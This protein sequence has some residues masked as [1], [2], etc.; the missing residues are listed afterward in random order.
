M[1]HTGDLQSGIALALQ[2]QKAVLCFIHDSS[3]KSTEW[4]Y[5]ILSD[6]LRERIQAQAIALKIQAGSQEAGFLTPIC[7]VNSNPAIIVIKDGALK[8]NLQA[9][10]VE[11][12]NLNDRLETIFDTTTHA[13]SP[14]ESDTAMASIRA[15]GPAEAATEE[16]GS[17]PPS[18]TST[19][20]SE[21]LTLPPPE[22]QFRLPNNAYDAMR[23]LTQCLLNSNTPPSEVYQSQLRILDRLPILRQEV[24]RLRSSTSL[25][26]LSDY[27]RD[28]LLRMPSAA[29]KAQAKAESTAPAPNP[30][31]STSAPTTSAPPQAQHAASTRPNPAGEYVY[32]QPSSSQLQSET[33]HDEEKAAAAAK[34]RQ[35]AALWTRMQRERQAKDRE[36]R[37]RIKSQIA[38]DREERRRLTEVRS[39]NDRIAEAEAAEAARAAKPATGVVRLQVRTFDGSTLR[40]TFQHDS[41][42]AND[43]RPWI[44]E[45]TDGNVPYNLKLI[46]TP[47]P[48]RN[49]EAS[50]EGQPLSDLGIRGSC[51]L[52]MVPVKGYVESYTGNTSHGLVGSAVSGG[53]NLV[54]GTAGALFGGVRSV[55]GY[56]GGNASQQGPAEMTESHNAA[57][58]AQSGRVKMRTLADQ[59]A[60]Q[61]DRRGPNH[62]LY[63]GN[64][65]NFEPNRDEDESR[66]DD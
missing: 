34:K 28:K 39:Q 24:Q 2:Q 16:T 50:E 8:A 45:Q 10:E 12:E 30:P 4:G 63:N 53:Y 33:E 58:T 1:F 32:I 6:S 36:A 21:Y 56:G 43:V 23:E 60:E 46:L 31:S 19:Q 40:N 3:D 14:P 51:T 47:L 41:K 49:I 22:G 27:A 26:T 18:S 64:Q 65:L 35:E 62:Q 7:P 52:V 37:E 59:R 17:W 48:N 9:A 5:A 38:Y 42:L 44:D 13:A 57:P 15:Q 61:M 29:I 25:P 54:R 55:L 66:K 20:S 11:T